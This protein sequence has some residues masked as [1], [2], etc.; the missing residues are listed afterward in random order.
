MNVLLHLKN[1]YSTKKRF[2]TFTT[3]GY[4][5]FICNSEG[6][7]FKRLRA[8][9]IYNS[10][11]VCVEI[12]HDKSCYHT[13]DAS[14]NNHQTSVPFVETDTHIYFNDN[15]T[16]VFA[17]GN[18]KSARRQWM[19]ERGFRCNGRATNALITDFFYRLAPEDQNHMQAQGW[20]P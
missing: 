16:F 3:C 5:I 11:S 18:G 6:Q 2:S 17:W 13:F 20:V 7:S 14:Y 9:F 12:P 10:L 1:K 8:Y 4:K 15:S 19:E